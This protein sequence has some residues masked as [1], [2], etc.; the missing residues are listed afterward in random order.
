M[1]IR[2]K[3]RLIPLAG[4]AIGIQWQ[5]WAQMDDLPFDDPTEPAELDITLGL[6]ILLLTIRFILPIKQKP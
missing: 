3:T 2:A 6:G 5:W 4:G 1:K